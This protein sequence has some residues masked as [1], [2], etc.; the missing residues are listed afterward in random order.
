MPDPI[1][2][3]NPTPLLPP[4]MA[5]AA[6]MPDNTKIKNIFFIIF[7]LLIKFQISDKL[8]LNLS[9]QKV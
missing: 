5:Q 7:S 6:N 1:P 8:Q 3:P 9:L 2:T 4:P